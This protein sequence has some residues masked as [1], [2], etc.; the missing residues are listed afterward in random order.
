MV[1]EIFSFLFFIVIRE[2]VFARLVCVVT[3]TVFV[4]IIEDRGAEGR[5]KVARARAA[6]APEGRIDVASVVLKRRW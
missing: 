5:G 4:G 6:V 3:A 1:F 2:W